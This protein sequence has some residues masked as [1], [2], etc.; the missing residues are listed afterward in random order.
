[1]IP[2][3]AIPWKLIGVGLLVAGVMLA[4]NRVSAWHAS[5]KALQGIRDELKREQ[6]CLPKSK[7]SERQEAFTEAIGHETVRIVTGYEAELAAIRGR[8]PVS[9]RV[10]DRG[11]VQDAGSASNPDGT[12][13]PGGMVSGSGRE[14][15]PALSALALKA[16][17]VT[18]QCRSLQDW[19]RALAK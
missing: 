1:M 11:G 7:C 8:K 10:C 18:A 15:G 19:N 12:P 6:D 9:V 13:A 3:T 17:E 5:H 2:L 14:I 4:G 16:D